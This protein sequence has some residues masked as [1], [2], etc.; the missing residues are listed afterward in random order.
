MKPR[1]QRYP[2]LTHDRDH[3]DG[4]P[5]HPLPLWAYS[6]PTASNKSQLTNESDLRSWE[7]PEKFWIFN[8]IWTYDL[9]DSSATD[10]LPTDLWSLAG[11]RGEQRCEF[12]LYPLYEQSLLKIRSQNTDRNIDSSREK[13]R[14]SSFW[15]FVHHVYLVIRQKS[16]VS[17]IPLGLFIDPKQFGIHTFVFYCILFLFSLNSFLSLFPVKQYLP[18]AVSP[19]LKMSERNTKNCSDLSGI[20]TEHI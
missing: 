20:N 12:N 19:T 1:N 11:S 3:Y 13:R 4:S 2:L 9:R 17:V 10:A 16:S 15:H 6:R 8:G 5:P 14:L 18:F 7:S